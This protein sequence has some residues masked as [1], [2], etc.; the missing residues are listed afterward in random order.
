M[1]IISI[2]IFPHELKRFERIVE[3]FKRALNYADNT[4]PISLRATLNINPALIEWGGECPRQTTNKF[5]GICKKI[6][7]TTTTEVK[8]D[9]T[10]LGVNEHRRDTI[11]EASVSDTIIFLDSDLYFDERLLAHQLNA[12]SLVQ[13]TNEYFIITPQIVKLWDDTWD[14]IVNPNF[15]NKSHQYHKTIDPRGIVNAE[16]G[17]VTLSEN[18]TFK[19]GGGW[20]NAISANLLK[21]IGIPDSFVGYGPDDTFIMECCKLMKRNGHGVQQYI[22]SNMVVTED[23]TPIQCSAGLK[24][25]IPNFRKECDKHFTQELSNFMRKL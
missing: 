18:K 1:I 7:V 2:H 11:N 12:I 17:K 19:W 16:Y 6:S 23:R 10:F 8:S 13:K 9:Q 20:F 4:S 25:N 15:I 5:T 24:E 14:C 22:L 21:Y 3:T